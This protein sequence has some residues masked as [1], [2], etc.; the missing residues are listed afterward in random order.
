MARELRLLLGLTA[1]RKLMP[2]LLERAISTKLVWSFS[3]IWP[4]NT[5]RLLRTILKLMRKMDSFDKASRLLESS[6]DFQ[7][8][9][10]DV[11]EK[12]RETYKSG[13]V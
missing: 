13:L 2:V 8:L 3:I 6:C 12:D 7:N 10:L 1:V 9:A 11:D 5:K 4:L